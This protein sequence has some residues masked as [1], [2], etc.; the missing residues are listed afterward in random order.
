MIYLLFLWTIGIT[1]MW[2]N[3]KISLRNYHREDVPGRFKAVFELADAMEEEISTQKQDPR[4]IPEKE[5]ERT[6]EEDLKG[7]RVAYAYPSSKNQ[8]PNRSVARDAIRKWV[9]NEKW[10]LPGFVPALIYLGLVMAKGTGYL[11]D[12][13]SIVHLLSAIGL[14]SGL[15]FSLQIGTTTKSRWLIILLLSVPFLLPVT[16]IALMVLHYRQKWRTGK[17]QEVPTS[18]ELL[19]TTK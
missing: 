18:N 11:V 1:L 17:M 13:G 15:W 7:G 3:A 12:F 5:L 2:L 8:L 9:I 10:W 19:P 6:I 16:V 14:F 4:D